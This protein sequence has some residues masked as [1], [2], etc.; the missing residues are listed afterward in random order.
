M[1]IK[2]ILLVAAIG[3][4]I[5]FIKSQMKSLDSTEASTGS[6]GSGTAPK[7]PVEPQ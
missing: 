7:G 5:W 2:V 3:A 6:G 1:A 4:A